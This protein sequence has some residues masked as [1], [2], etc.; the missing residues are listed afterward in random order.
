M[1]NWFEL[2]RLCVQPYKRGDKLSLKDADKFL[3][4]DDGVLYDENLVQIDKD[5]DESIVLEADDETAERFTISQNLLFM[6]VEGISENHGSGY[7]SGVQEVIDGEGVEDAFI[8]QFRDDIFLKWAKEAFRDEYEDLLWD[9]SMGFFLLC[10]MSVQ[11]GYG[12]YHEDNY[13]QVESVKRLDELVPQLK[14]NGD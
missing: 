11:S 13:C 2:A 5:W 12:Y 7:F 9:H 3:N 14:I 6:W 4:D 8:L 1:E 10:E